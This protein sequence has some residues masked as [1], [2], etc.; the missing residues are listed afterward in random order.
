MTLQFGNHDYYFWDLQD[1]DVKLPYVC[2]STQLNIGCM[3]D[4][5]GTD[6]D[7]SAKKTEGGETCLPWNTTGLLQIFDG[8]SQWNH[9]Y[10]RNPG[11]LDE[12]PLCFIDSETYDYCSIPRCGEQTQRRDTTNIAAICNEV[13]GK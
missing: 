9:S 3:R 1:L 10:C 2:E 13:F 12:R 4:Q 5:I 7:G 11:G 8:Q 6:Y